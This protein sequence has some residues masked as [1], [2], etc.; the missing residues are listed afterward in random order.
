MLTPSPTLSNYGYPW[1]LNTGPTANPALPSSAVSAM[2]AGS[3]IIWIDPDHD[4]VVVIRWIDK[5]A[6]DGFL[7]RVIGAMPA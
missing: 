1:W 2:G 3:N 4:L 5:A 6:V 7:S